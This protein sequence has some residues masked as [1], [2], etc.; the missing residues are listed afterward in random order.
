MT[1]TKLEQQ[2]LVARLYSDDPKQAEIATNTV[3]AAVRRARG[4]VEAAAADLG[5]SKRTFYRW[6]SHAKLLDLAAELRAKAGATDLGT[7]AAVGTEEQKREALGAM[8]NARM[9]KRA[10]RRSKQSAE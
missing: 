10:A 3:R 6:I 7:L 5:V 4:D 1:L 8:F 2:I 9:S